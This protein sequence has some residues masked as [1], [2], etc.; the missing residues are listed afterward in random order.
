MVKK[1]LKNNQTIK[2]NQWYY[3]VMRFYFIFFCLVFFA[4]CGSSSKKLIKNTD[5]ILDS[6]EFKVIAS[7]FADKIGAYVEK[8][9]AANPDSDYF[10]AL[11]PIKNNTLNNLPVD[12]LGFDLVQQLLTKNI[13]TIRREDREEALGEI[14]LQLSG[15]S[16]NQVAVGQMKTPNYFIKIKIEENYLQ[17]NREKLVEQ[18]ILLELRSVATQLV[19]L[20]D[21]VEFLKEKKT[22][23]TINW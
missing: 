6:N 20:S 12:V 23:R 22:F 11:L 18:S 3:I 21:K 5:T 10:L 19:V 17:R 1:K 4:A 2:L 15:F 16:D 9:K 8:Q 7:R 13:Y 14:E